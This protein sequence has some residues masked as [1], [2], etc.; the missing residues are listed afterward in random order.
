MKFDVVV[1][2]A[3]GVD[4]LPRVTTLSLPWNRMQVSR[5]LARTLR[6]LREPAG[7]TDS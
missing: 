6:S 1:T 3:I 4:S 2:V 7:E 5:M